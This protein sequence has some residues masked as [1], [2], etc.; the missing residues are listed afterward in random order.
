MATEQALMDIS[1]TSA[2]DLRTKQYY[3]VKISSSR[4]VNIGTLGAAFGVLQN[5]PNTGEFATIRNRGISKVI[6]GGTIAAG[7]RITSDS[8]AKAIKLTPFASSIADAYYDHCGIAL[9]SAVAGDIFSMECDG[10]TPVQIS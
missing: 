3:F 8:A 2:A 7:D 4:T 9:E 5:K 1:M 6:A 10:P